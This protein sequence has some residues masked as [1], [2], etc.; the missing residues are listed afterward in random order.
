MPPIAA[1]G[2]GTEQMKILWRPIRAIVGVA[3]GWVILAMPCSAETLILQGSSTFNS[4]LMVPYQR[5][6]EAAAGRTLKVIPSKS[7]IGFIALLE[8]RADLAMI[9][10]SLESELAQLRASRPDLP[11]HLLRSY[12]VSK[13]RIAFAVNPD[14]P[15]RSVTLAQ[16][17]QVLE[18][19]IGNW[20]QLGGPDLPIQVV[21]VND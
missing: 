13:V 21:S 8:G 17:R 19:E 12:L 7:S 2:T 14:N 4:Y 10:A 16:I 6:I 3:C 1:R 15:V 5:D 18:G 20:R 9:S 11:Y